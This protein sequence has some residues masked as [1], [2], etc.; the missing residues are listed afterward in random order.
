[1]HG[2]QT[3]SRQHHWTQME[4]NA[5]C[6]CVCDEMCPAEHAREVRGLVVFESI[7]AFAVFACAVEAIGLYIVFFLVVQL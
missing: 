7:L 5:L 6:L 1:M 2:V 3:A 4:E